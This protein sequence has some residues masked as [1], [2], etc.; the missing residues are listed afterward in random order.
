MRLRNRKA[1]LLLLLLPSLAVAAAVADKQLDKDSLATS[2]GAASGRRFST[3]DAPVD[4]K[5]GKPHAGPFVD[6]GTPSSDSKELP[7]LKDRPADPTI[8]DGKRIPESNDG[9]MDDKNRA[10]PKKGTTGTEGGVSEKEKERKLKEEQTGEKAETKPPTPKE[11][12]PLPHSE[13][14]KIAAGS[15]GKA[16][17][18]EVRQFYQTVR[19]AAQLTIFPETKRSSRQNPR[20]VPSPS[21]FCGQHRPS[22]YSEGWETREELWHR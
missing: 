5:D 9:V 13:Q 16:S 12:P 17:G 2:D 3:K 10:S 20:Q 4:G 19:Q 1:P 18:L 7:A 6:L 11:A 21:R 15:E 14:E 22:R 8:V